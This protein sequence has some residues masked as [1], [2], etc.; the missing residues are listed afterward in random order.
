MDTL[1]G[2]VEDKKEAS[3]REGAL[4]A[5]ELLSEKLGKLFEP[6]IIYIL[7]LLLGCFGDVVPHVRTATEDASRMIMGHLT[8]SGVKLVLPTLLKGLEDKAWRTKQG[9]VQL[10]GSMA[11]CAPK[12]LGQQLPSLLLIALP[13]VPTLTLISCSTVR[14]L[15]PLDRAQ[16]Q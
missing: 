16:A 4:L 5:F 7:P 13:L 3:S 6:Y 1:K 10:L 11:H 8:A 12:Q 14:C 9:S 2:L 15:P